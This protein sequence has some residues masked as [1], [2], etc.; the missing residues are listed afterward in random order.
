[1]DRDIAEL[2]GKISSITA[3]R[4]QGWLCWK[5]FPAPAFVR[6]AC[7]GNKR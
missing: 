1:M 2:S 3:L 5:F 7:G 4:K 6:A